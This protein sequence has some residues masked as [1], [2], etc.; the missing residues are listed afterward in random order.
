I[1]T[2]FWPRRSTA[3][4][5]PLSRWKSTSA[6]A[7]YGRIRQR[8]SSAT[9]GTCGQRSRLLQEPPDP[10]RDQ[11]RVIGRPARLGLSQGAAETFLPQ[12]RPEETQ[13]ARVEPPPRPHPVHE[14]HD[15]APETT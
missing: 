10:L 9:A 14:A 4:Q 11:L 7:M 15:H 12:R 1:S 2:R 8:L 13:V 3:V 5:S 6:A